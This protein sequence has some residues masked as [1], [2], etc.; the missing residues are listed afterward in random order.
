VNQVA[1]LGTLGFVS[2]SDDMQVKIW[3]KEGTNL[4]V[5]GKPRKWRFDGMRNTGNQ[6]VERGND[7]GS[8][9]E[10]EGYGSLNNSQS[11]FVDEDSY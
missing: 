6:D 10:M 3:G 1:W 5:T 7:S 11:D 8:D 2:A 4:Q 9:E